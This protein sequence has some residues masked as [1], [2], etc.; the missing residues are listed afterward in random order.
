[1]EGKKEERRVGLVERRDFF[2]PLLY[3]LPY[4]QAPSSTRKKEKLNVSSSSMQCRIRIALRRVLDLRV[5]SGVALPVRFND[6][7]K[8]SID[9]LMVLLLQQV[10]SIAGF[11]NKSDQRHHPLLVLT[12]R[13]N[14]FPP[15]FNLLPQLSL[16]LPISSKLHPFDPLQK[17]F[18]RNI[19]QQQ[20]R[21]KTI[22]FRR[23]PLS[24]RRD[25]ENEISND[26]SANEIRDPPCPNSSY[27]TVPWKLNV[28][29]PSRWSKKPEDDLGRC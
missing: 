3:T 14:S 6:Q 5:S 17:P 19:I 20:P 11:V 29:S 9:L 27:Q 21:K 2:P 28:L 4:L 26:Q 15:D 24:N 10:P 8:Q 23:F 7:S 13:P 25:L 12:R 1:M 18:S 16:D 22:S